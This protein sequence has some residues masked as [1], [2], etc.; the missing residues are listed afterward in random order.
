MKCNQV[1]KDNVLICPFCGKNQEEEVSGLNLK[2][3]S[4]FEKVERKVAPDGY[5]RDYYHEKGKR[6]FQ[7]I[8]DM[9]KRAFDLDGVTEIVEYWT[10][11]LF[12]II[13]VIISLISGVILTS[14]DANNPSPINDSPVALTLFIMTSIMIILSVI[15]VVT[16]TVRRLHDAGCSGNWYLVTFLPFVGSLIVVYLT[17]GPFKRNEYN[18]DYEKAPDVA[19][20][21]I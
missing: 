14:P 15:P 7:A 11:A 9:Y 21:N 6:G 4:K 2:N 12:I 13:I 5:P 3:F 18:R 16:S 8:K 10:Q 17:I 19:K 20:L 1:I